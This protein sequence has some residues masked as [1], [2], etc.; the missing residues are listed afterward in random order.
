MKI[1]TRTGDDGSTG[2][3]GGDR[4]RKSHPRINAYGTVDEVNAVLGTALAHIPNEAG[5]DVLR[6]H[7][8]HIQRDLFVL[9]S[10]LATPLTSKATVPRIDD[11]SVSKL[12]RT[13]DELESELE[14]LANFILPGGHPAAATLHLARTTCRR[15]ERL[16]VDAME[17]DT[18]NQLTIV[19]LNRLSDLLFVAARFAN[20]IAGVPDVIWKA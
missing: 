1:Y 7:L 9:G 13:I 14:P 3:F 20:H 10:D 17:G 6:A 11:A 5:F 8:M 2:L 12:E 19:Y 16:A 15:A 4:V 18:L